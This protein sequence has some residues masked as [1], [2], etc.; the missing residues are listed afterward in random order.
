MKYYCE[1]CKY[2]TAIKHNFQKHLSTQKHNRKKFCHIIPNLERKSTCQY[3]CE[4]CN[5]FLAYKSQARVHMK[6]K[7]HKKNKEKGGKIIRNI[8]YSTDA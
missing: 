3:Y 4:A 7:K 5:I 8:H 2:S 1:K 6:T